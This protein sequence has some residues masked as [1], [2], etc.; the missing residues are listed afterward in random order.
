MDTDFAGPGLQSWRFSGILLYIAQD[1]VSA[2]SV[3]HYGEASVIL[4]MQLL[5]TTAR[6]AAFLGKVTM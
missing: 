1:L 2:F 3:F 4:G 5:K 6:I